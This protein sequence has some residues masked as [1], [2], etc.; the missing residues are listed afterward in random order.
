MSVQELMAQL[1]GAGLQLRRDGDR[2]VL[3]GMTAER[4]AALLAE[5]RGHTGTRAAVVDRVADPRPDHIAA[6]ITDPGFMSRTFGERCYGGS[7]VPE[8]LVSVLEEV[9]EHFRRAIVDREFL[10]RLAQLNREFAGRETPTIW[11]ENLSAQIGCNLYLKRE[12]LLHGGAH[13]VNSTIGQILLARYMGKKRIISETGAGQHGVATAMTAA[14]LGFPTDVYMGVLDM[15]R[16]HS[17]VLRM[18]LYGARV[19]PVDTGRGSLKDAINEAMRDWITNPGESYHC[20]G[21]AAGPFPYPSLVKYFQRVIGDEARRQMIEA[22]G[23]LPTDVIACVGGGSNAIGMFAAFLEDEN[24]RLWAAE[25]AGTGLDGTRH[26]ATLSLGTAGVFHGMKSL[27]LQNEDGQ[28]AATHSI[29]A[30]LDYPGV[31]PEL[32]DLKE[33]GRIGVIAVSDEEVIEAFEALSR[34]EGIIPAFE[35]AHALAAALRLAREE[36]G[37]RSLLVCLSGRG[38][39]DLDIYWKHAQHEPIR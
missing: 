35:S 26:A 17:N 10:A 12:D 6:G 15:Q 7:Y 21:T 22:H 34:R 11:A 9:L 27:W 39:K 1:A 16:Q 8:S 24:V 38:D 36:P 23:S 13:K 3:S 29:A 5:W 4:D 2:L 30:G 19:V 32:V 14:K 20:F 37:N 28:I 31:G 25:P 18:R 33:R